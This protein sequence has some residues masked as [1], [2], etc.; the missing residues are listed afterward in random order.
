M[1]GRVVL[2]CRSLE[3]KLT[4]KTVALTNLFEKRNTEKNYVMVALYSS[5]KS[6]E[7]GKRKA[8]YRSKRHVI[9]MSMDLGD[10]ICTE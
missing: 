9:K 4:P 2:T 7:K 6:P 8:L 1:R 10:F 3:Q 5:Q